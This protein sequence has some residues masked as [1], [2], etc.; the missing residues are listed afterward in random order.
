MP[1]GRIIKALLDQYLVK[2]DNGRYKCSAKGLFRLQQITP[3]VGDR[4]F[5]E[6]LDEE[7]KEGQ[8]TQICE[9]K[10]ELIRPKASN[11][12]QVCVVYSRIR[13]RPDFLLID[14]VIAAALMQ[15]LFVIL[16]ENKI[17]LC[18]DNSYKEEM[19]GYELAGIPALSISAFKGINMVELAGLLSGKTTILAG[20]SGVGK[21]SIIN[22][23]DD[24]ELMETGEVSKKNK[25]G[26]H[27]TRHAELIELENEGYIIDTP[28]FSNHDLPQMRADELKWYYPEFVP[29]EGGCRFSGCLHLKEPGCVI[30]QAVE[31]KRIGAGRYERYIQLFDILKDKE[32]NKYK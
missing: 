4:V 3:L 14:K 7:E 12:D 1:E 9:R 22:N 2:T 31:E 26:K 24:S 28:G 5:I 15:G 16:C 6:I 25:K 20:Q 23:L 18:E 13:P 11:V 29:L 10:N 8:I 19:Q 21:S 27:T 30:K 17:D 32:L